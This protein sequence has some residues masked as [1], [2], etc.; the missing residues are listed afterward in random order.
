MIIHV[1]I[2]TDNNR[3]DITN[4]EDTFLCIQNDVNFRLM[5]LQNIVEDAEMMAEAAED[6]EEN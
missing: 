1:T 5:T 2:Y 3:V 4:K 6:A